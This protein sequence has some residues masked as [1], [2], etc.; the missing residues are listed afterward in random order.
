MALIFLN[1]KKLK[2]IEKNEE[3]IEINLSS[4]TI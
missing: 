2:N 4:T 1:N 3:N